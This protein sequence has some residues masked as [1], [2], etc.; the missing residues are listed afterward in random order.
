MT[1]EMN[2]ICLHCGEPIEG[3]EGKIGI[4]VKLCPA[5]HLR[6]PTTT[7]ETIPNFTFG[8]N[9]DAFNLIDIGNPLLSNAIEANRKFIEEEGRFPPD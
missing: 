9:I 5:R 7:S 8:P 2:V 3:S 6:R 1:T 4:H